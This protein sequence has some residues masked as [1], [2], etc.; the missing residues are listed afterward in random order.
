MHS[1]NV[2]PSPLRQLLP[3][4]SCLMSFASVLAVLVIYMDTTEIRHQQFRLNMSRDYELYG[5]PQDD[6]T[7]LKFVREIHMKK[8]PMAFLKNM[9]PG[10]IN[11]TDRHELASEI[12]DLIGKY[13]N[14]RKNGFF[15]QSLPWTSRNMM[16]APWLS[17]T[18]KWGGLIVEPDP[19]QYFELRKENARRND[20]QVVHACLSSTGYPKEITIHHEGETHD[21][22]INSL[23]DEDS[24]FRTRVKCFPLYTLML[25]VNHTKIDVLSL[26]CQGQEL[27]ILETVPF[28]RVTITVITI[29]LEDYF[30]YESS[31]D[32]YV[33]NVTTYL[34]TKSYKL[35]KQL[36]Q[37]YIFQLNGCDKN[38]CP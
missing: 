34:K 23:I 8:Y 22:K 19:Q 31:A 27:Q 18:L 5:V 33:Q 3:L 32:L 13:L 2:G 7:L 17:D 6:P 26:G 20:V 21:V 36:H 1:G 9:A 4:L 37:N 15:V 14:K 30:R 28:D 35:V 12:A 10:I 38:K 24:G 16:T 25:A 29:H 11:L